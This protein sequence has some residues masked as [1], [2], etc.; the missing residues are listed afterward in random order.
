[1][2]YP[3]TATSPAVGLSRV[4]M[5]CR[6]VDFPLPDGPTT[7]TSSPRVTLKSTPRRARTGGVVGYSLVT[8]WSESTTSD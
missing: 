5:M 4:P 3:A 7:P 2:L 8:P 1:M 6:R